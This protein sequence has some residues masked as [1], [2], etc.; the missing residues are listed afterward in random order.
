MT[1]KW[2]SVVAQSQPQNSLIYSHLLAS[3]PPE[4]SASLSS[5][6]QPVTPSKIGDGDKLEVLA[7]MVEKALPKGP[8][9]HMKLY[10]RLG[11]LAAD[12]AKNCTEKIQVV[13]LR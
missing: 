8:A 9:K 3:F 4:T 2:D 1:I 11:K 13:V 5:N 10:M 6:S 7:H 12:E